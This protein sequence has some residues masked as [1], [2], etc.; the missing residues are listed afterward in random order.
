[1]I[2]TANNL[3]PKRGKLWRFVASV[4]DWLQAWIPER[5]ATCL[6][7]ADLNVLS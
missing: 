6:R 7:E 2:D 5:S 1:M 3:V 4:G